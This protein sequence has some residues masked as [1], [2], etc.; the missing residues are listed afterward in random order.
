MGRNVLRIEAPSSAADFDLLP[1]WHAMAGVDSDS[2]AD[3]DN[4]RKALEEGCLGVASDQGYKKNLAALQSLNTE[5]Q[6]YARTAVR[7][8]TF[9]GEQVGILVMGAHSLLW[10]LLAKLAAAE[11]TPTMERI[12]RSTATILTWAK[13]HLVAVHPD[14]RGRGHGARLLRQAKAIAARDGLMTMYGQFSAD[15]TELARFYTAGGFTVLE[16]GA[17]LPI[18]MVTGRDGDVMR[19]VQTERP[20]VWEGK[21]PKL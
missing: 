19:C 9:N 10:E 13:I 4:Y 11:T 16:P 5:Q 17:P 3:A 15:R 20:F 2:A 12:A 18:R 1:M 6:F 8:L 14:H 7:L 21:G